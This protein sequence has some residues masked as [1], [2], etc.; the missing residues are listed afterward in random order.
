LDPDP[1]Y[2][3]VA[4]DGSLHARWGARVDGE[5]HGAGTSHAPGLLLHYRIPHYLE[6]H[7]EPG[8][9]VTVPLR[10]KPVYGVVA[11]LAASSPVQPTQPINR[12]VDERPLVPAPMMELA[13]WIANYYCCTLWQALAPMLPPGVAR[14]AITTI[15]LVP[16]FASPD[17]ESDPLI[18]A[19]GRRQ[20]QVVSLL[21]NA[22]R[23]T[24]TLSKLKHRYSG[25]ASGLETALRGL[26]RD[27]LVTRR[28]ELPTPRTRP[29][30]ERMI[31]LQ[32]PSHEV[33][34][35]L[36]EA[37]RRAPLQAAALS[38]LLR[39]SGTRGQETAS[40]QELM[41]DPWPLTPGKDGW[42]RLRDL[43]LHT[44]ATSA[45]VA[46]LERKN[47]VELA[48]RTV[49]PK[50]LP[51][52][53]ASL[54]DEPPVLTSAQ[55][56]ALKEIA[57]ALR[58][59]KQNGGP[60]S[61]GAE[62]TQHLTPN[63]QHPT[64]LLHGVTGSGKTE[65]YLRAIGMALR[66]GRQALVLV[67]EISL[68]PQA[69]HRFASRYP[70][71]VALVH[72]QLP[73][74]QQFDEWRRI[75]EGHAD[76]VVGSRSAVFAP[77]PRLGL[78]VVDEEHEW[79]YKQ[80]H[81][82]R[83]HA[84]DVALKRAELTG[85]VVILGSATPDLA[86]YHRGI[87]GEY[88]LLSLPTRVGRRRARD[89]SHLIAELPMPPVQ[90]VDMRAELRSGNSSIFSR[91]LQSGLDATFSRREQAI[92]YLNRRGSNSFMLCRE[93]G[94]VPACR[95][96]DV[97]LVYHA[98]VYG[99]LCHRCNA[100]SLAPRECPKCSSSQIKGFG[101][102]TQ[103]V[104]DEVAAH[105][106]R[107]RVL[108]WDR[109]TA[110]RHGGHAGIMDMFA[111]GEAD[112]LVGTQMIAKGLDI[113]RVTMVGVVSAD[114]GLYLPDFRA[115]E[116]SLQLLMQVAGRA[117]RRAETTHSRVVVQ[118]YNPDHYAI[119]AAARHDY[120]G[121]YSGEIRFRAEHA[122]PPYGQL[123]RLV[124]SSPS[125]ERCEQETQTV[126]R[127]LRRKAEELAAQRPSPGSTVADVLGP[128]PCY[129]HKVRGRYRWQ[130]LLRAGDVS[131]LLDGFQPGHGWSMDVD[132][133]SLL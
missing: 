111:R 4:L 79:A 36:S 121:F 8:H 99:M 40:D 100:H 11:S 65:I 33:A 72:S 24:L 108:R 47:L 88:R 110:S 20:K 49:H 54:H 101:V 44:G 125:N 85:S 115:P 56:A 102:G 60:A 71:R 53:A 129:V 58:E 62:P 28:T 29:Q 97:P 5:A 86:T 16:D 34:E 104:V 38:W 67:P 45:T 103:R 119:Q 105:F 80:D 87:R 41:P 84:R 66:A 27:G 73:P 118:T 116:R 89:G 15:G 120:K 107:A 9:L 130:V 117:G 128:A 82:P 37:A 78:I 70:G 75:R 93:C 112:V 55:A 77:L 106:P 69:V 126:A 13:R 81:A 50:P 83:Y 94:H 1:A 12:L 25:A 18:A 30:Q 43:Y 124:Y 127:H 114:T 32:A 98:D 133:L 59:L 3:I 132:P 90:I 92:L 91:A 61:D 6:G 109:D 113:P 96:C 2:A 76:I 51:P 23:S 46:A 21:Q 48:E 123:A 31:R 19:L 39:M 42:Q 122:Y 68:T 57:E 10:G 35:A 63:T 7:V 74:R 52:N 64:F 26:E 95:R 14:R 22:P 131:P 17:G